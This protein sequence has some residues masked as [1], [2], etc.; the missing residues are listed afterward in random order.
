MLARHPEIARAGFYPA[1]VLCDTQ[2]IERG[3]IEGTGGPRDWPPL[4]YI[5][6]SRLRRGDAAA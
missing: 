1:L 3:H 2:G 6:F 4:L 5:C